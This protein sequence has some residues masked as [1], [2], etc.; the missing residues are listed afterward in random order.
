MA[1]ASI[2]L[3]IFDA[4]KRSILHKFQ[5]KTKVGFKSGLMAYEE[6]DAPADRTTNPTKVVTIYGIVT[7]EDVVNGMMPVKDGYS[8]ARNL[9]IQLHTKLNLA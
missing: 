1:L 4:V 6:K 3:L 5:A 8:F 9:V 2:L 7:M